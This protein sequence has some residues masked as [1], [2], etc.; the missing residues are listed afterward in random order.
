[1]KSAHQRLLNCESYKLLEGQLRNPNV[2]AR[3]IA[4]YL[5]EN[6]PAFD[7]MQVASIKR[8]VLRFRKD[9]TYMEVVDGLRRAAI[10][11]KIIEQ[12]D[13]VRELEWAVLMQRKRIESLMELEKETRVPLQQTCNEFEE[14]RKLADTLIAA[15][16]K[17]GVY[18]TVP[19][20]LA[21]MEKSELT[22]KTD[23]E[24]KQRIVERLRRMGW[25]EE[26]IETLLGIA[27]HK[28]ARVFE[29]QRVK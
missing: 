25:P 14:L 26:R 24:G 21:V 8:E 10:E 23:D 29:L 12:I 13:E 15:K 18:D 20:K 27:P 5:A 22:V 19:E 3:K 16:Q 6:D 7:G 9:M 1:M 4:E 2:P 17:L 28:V 11:N